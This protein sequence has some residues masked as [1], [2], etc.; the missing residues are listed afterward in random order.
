M[1]NRIQELRK[2]RN[3]TQI[4]LS[5]QIGVSQETISAYEKN[6]HDPTPAVLIKLSQKLNA[7]IDYIL[8]QSEHRQVSAPDQITQDER[9][10]LDMFR[11]ANPNQRRLAVSY[12]QFLI[13]GGR[14][15]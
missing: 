11:Q 15:L 5:T 13:R 8:C 2:E 12:L 6:K 4:A 3:M 14:E 1:K 7:S 10:L 9:V